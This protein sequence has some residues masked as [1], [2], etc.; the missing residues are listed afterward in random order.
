M[1]MQIF[2]TYGKLF[3][4]AA[5]H[6]INLSSMAPILCLQNRANSEEI[7]PPLYIQTGLTCNITR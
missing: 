3:E 7:C 1:N 4:S 5:S 6:Y 2:C